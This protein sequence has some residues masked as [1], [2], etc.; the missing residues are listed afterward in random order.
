[1]DCNRFQDIDGDDE[2]VVA[3]YAVD[4]NL[5]ATAVMTLIDFFNTKMLIKI[6]LCNDTDRALCLYAEIF[7]I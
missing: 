3:G 7:K 5:S 6:D 4:L 2:D 1:M